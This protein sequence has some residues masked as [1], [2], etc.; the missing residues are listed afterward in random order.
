[1]GTE[2]LQCLYRRCLDGGVRGERQIVLRSEIDAF[3]GLALFG[4]NGSAVCGRADQSARVGPYLRRTTS[5]LPAEER[6]RTGKNVGSGWPGEVSQTL[7]ERPGGRQRRSLGNLAK[8]HIRSTTFLQRA[9]T[10]HICP[11]GVLEEH[12]HTSRVRAPGQRCKRG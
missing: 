12:N 11:P 1:M 7:T 3:D 10:S 6:L 5:I 9:Q 4:L 2:L 8:C